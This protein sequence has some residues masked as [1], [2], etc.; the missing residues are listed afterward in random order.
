MNFWELHEFRKFISYVD[1][2][3]YNVLFNLLF[4]TGVRKGEA[5]ALTWNDINFDSKYIKI[6]K[7]CSYISGVGQGTVPCPNFKKPFDE[8]QKVFY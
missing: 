5:L 2:E 7:S 1:D 3:V 4:F 8:N 6:S